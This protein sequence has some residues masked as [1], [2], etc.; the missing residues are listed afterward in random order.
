MDYY[1]QEADYNVHQENMHTDY[2]SSPYELIGNE[3]IGIS[4]EVTR[5]TEAGAMVHNYR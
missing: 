3:P 1:N 5:S 4:L 2:S